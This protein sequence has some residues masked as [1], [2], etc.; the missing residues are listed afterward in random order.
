MVTFVRGRYESFRNA[1]PRGGRLPRDLWEAR[2]RT[3]LI[4]LWLHV[5]AIPVYGLV[6]HQTLL[7]SLFEA[8]LVG[9]F[10]LSATFNGGAQLPRGIRAAIAAGGLMT[11]SA[12]LV[13][14]AGGAIE[15]HFHFFVMVGLITLYQDWVP[16][17]VAIAFVALHH[18]VVGVLLPRY[19]YDHDAAQ[20][21][22]LLWAGIH[23]LFVLGASAAHI[24]SW[25]LVETQH[26][27]S[28]EEIRA[29]GRRFQALIEHGS[30]GITVTD[31]EGTIVYES[32]SITSMLGFDPTERIG[33]SSMDFVHADDVPL[34]VNLF[35][36]LGA[37]GANE[38][39][40]VRLLR[41]DGTS[42]WAEVHI[43]N[44]LDQPDVGG[45]VA[46]F[47]DV[48]ERKALEGRLAHQ[49]FHDDLTGL[50]N[51]ALFQDRVEHA[52]AA[53]SRT[54]SLLALIF[55]DLDDFK[56]IND[57]LGHAAGDEVLVDVA[58]RIKAAVRTGDTCARFGGDE[59]AILLENLP[60]PGLAYEVGARILESL[61]D[62]LATASGVV[63][64][65]ASLGIVFSTHGSEASELIR[66]ADLAMYEA[67]GQGKG[68]F[69]I[70][71]QGMHDAV[72]E[73]LA[74][75]A[76]LRR[77]I[78]ADEFV[79][80]YQP[81]IELATGRVVGAEALARWE[82]PQRGLLLP[83]SFIELA[84]ETGLIVP[85]GRTILRRA[86]IDAARWGGAFG[87]SPKLSVNLS[88]KQLQ[89]ESIV[90]DVA[91]I[92]AESGLEPGCLTLEITESVLIA[93]PDAAAKVLGRLKGLGITLA[94]DDFG[95]GYSSLSY[96]GRFPVDVL[97]ID[98][99]FV[100]G[101]SD[102][103]TAANG[104][105]AALLE[106]IVGLGQMLQ[107]SV[108]AEGIE[109][110]DQLARLDAL[111]CGMGQG[112]LFAYPM[113]DGEFN[114]PGSDRIA[115]TSATHTSGN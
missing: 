102:D 18:G 98:R 69:E 81:V 106:A 93:D 13:H 91:E 97:K 84:E 4:V 27:R 65:N 55:I 26:E 87:D 58:R 50:A 40:E 41:K 33:H 12:V 43:S 23:A 49:A 103:P 11:A 62:E 105:E 75:K 38:S 107:L 15:M 24:T 89:H 36:R 45:I 71:E 35:E 112:Y 66:N 17:L 114:G 21:K 95:T 76:D 14:L 3:V 53:Q 47:R 37:P 72:I 60:Q 30:D 54:G 90:E 16:F 7:H 80:H 92:L 77:G 22:P 46:N 104:T 73:R 48:T 85:L 70:F 111:G 88:A 25:R 2:H 68:R 59:F 9:V 44:L 20:T 99:S 56:N 110:A 29:H 19:V 78:E 109:S 39:V 67:K 42:R 64:L 28:E 63:E 86:C 101:M 1:L 79:P 94:L 51:R 61:R 74:H 32:P 34:V 6:R 113:P 82:H 5:A 8:S 108:V 100:A 52:L 115:A 83:A 10:A 57:A 31:A 96:L